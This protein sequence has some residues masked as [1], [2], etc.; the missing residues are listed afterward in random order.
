MEFL[1]FIV[2]LIVFVA[3][4]SS[5]TEHNNWRVRQR[6]ISDSDAVYSKETG[7]YV[8]PLKIVQSSSKSLSF[9]VNVLEIC[10][11]GQAVRYVN[12]NSHYDH[13]IDENRDDES[14]W[15]IKQVSSIAKKLVVEI[16]PQNQDLQVKFNELERLE[17]LASSS[18]LYTLQANLY[19]RAKEQVAILLESGK[20]LDKEC[21]KFVR[22]TLIGEELMKYNSENIPDIAATKISLDYQC[23]QVS[24]EYQKLK[25]E[26]QAYNSLKS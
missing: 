14:S 21:D 9:K 2:F 15:A 11:D 4:F 22:E 5:T 13:D 7:K 10:L 18:D 3:I 16:R 20:N 1:L 17:E 26:I 24:S 25:S 19:R 8:I 23:D 6:K 12:Y